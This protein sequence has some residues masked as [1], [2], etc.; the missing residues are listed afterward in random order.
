MDHSRL[1]FHSNR[2]S[3]RLLLPSSTA[4]L[5]SFGSPIAAKGAPIEFELCQI[6]DFMTCGRSGTP[7]G[8][9]DPRA[10]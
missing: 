6:A 2:E 4:P 10:A 5:R 1:T 7:P 3:G 8:E 9:P